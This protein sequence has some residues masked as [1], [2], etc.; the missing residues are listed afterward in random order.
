MDNAVNERNGLHFSFGTA[1]LAV[2]VEEVERKQVHLDLDVLDLDVLALPGTEL[3]KLEQ[4]LLLHVPRDRF[5]VDHERLGTLFNALRGMIV[6]SSAPRTDAARAARG[7]PEARTLARLAF[8][9]WVTNSGYLTV[10]S[11]LLREK[12]R[13]LPSSR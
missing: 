6:R 4:P 10:M 2:Q 5:R 12:T 7:S 9:S 13:T 1:H 11:S 8:G 3:L